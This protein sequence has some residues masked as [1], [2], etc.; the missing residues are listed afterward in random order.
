MRVTA[1]LIFLLIAFCAFVQ[2]I[3]IDAQSA[4]HQI[5]QAMML[6]SLVCSAGFGCLILMGSRKDEQ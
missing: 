5:Y 3:T 4:M 6:L 2:F 1:G